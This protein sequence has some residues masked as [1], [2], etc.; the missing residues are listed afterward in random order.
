MEEPSSKLSSA[1]KIVLIALFRFG[2]K[3]TTQSNQTLARKT[4]F[5][6]RWVEKIIERLVVK[7]VID[8]KIRTVKDNGEA[9]SRR[10]ITP[11]FGPKKYSVDFLP[12]VQS[13]GQQPNSKTGSNRMVRR[14]ATERSDDLLEFREEKIKEKRIEDATPSPVSTKGQTPT[15]LADGEKDAKSGVEQ[16]KHSFGTANRIKSGLSPREFEHRRQQN[17]KAL[18]AGQSS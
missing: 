9:K 8:R 1:E 13:F 15:L 5:S 10:L 11:L 18:Q 14:E 17:I 12:T 2:L 16:F 3:P 6:V 7:K 4:G